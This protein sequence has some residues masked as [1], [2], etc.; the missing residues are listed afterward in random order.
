MECIRE[1]KERDVVSGGN[2]SGCEEV[3]RMGRW[4]RWDVGEGGCDLIH[5]SGSV[6]RGSH[7]E[8]N[9][10][11]GEGD[12]KGGGGRLSIALLSKKQKSDSQSNV[13]NYSRSRDEV[14][15]NLKPSEN[16]VA[17][18]ADARRDNSGIRDEA[19][20]KSHRRTMWCRA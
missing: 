8:R 10:V 13:W 9:G 12:S 1:T 19:R 11:Q 14:M 2:Y 16:P 18:F 20:I 5:F 4:R 6:R 17:H 15:L 7:G 3:G